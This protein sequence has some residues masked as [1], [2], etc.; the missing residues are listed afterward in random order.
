MDSSCPQGTF[1][2]A[3]GYAWWWRLIRKSWGVFV[4]WMGV[5]TGFLRNKIRGVSRRQLEMGQRWDHSRQRK[6]H[7]QMP[8]GLQSRISSRNRR[9]GP[10]GQSMVVSDGHCE[11]AGQAQELARAWPSS[12]GTGLCLSSSHNL[13]LRNAYPCWLALSNG[14]VALGGG[15]HSPNWV[16]RLIKLG[17]SEDLVSPPV[18]RSVTPDSS[19]LCWWPSWW[20]WFCDITEGK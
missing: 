1:S 4:D 10:W 13:S 9:P 20:R 16:Q 15:G 19:R 6:Q 12:L 2:V 8:C 17:F 3:P 5:R 11:K 7:V 14:R 18:L